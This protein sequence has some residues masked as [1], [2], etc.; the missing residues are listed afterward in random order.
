M[1]R[2]DIRTSRRQTSKQMAGRCPNRF[3]KTI[4][5]KNLLEPR[6]NVP[7][8][9]LMETLA[10]KQDAGVSIRDRERIAILFIASLE[11][12]LEIDAPQIVRILDV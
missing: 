7:I 5:L 12:T 3:R 6:M 4:G 10:L 11:L 8:S 1:E 2:R 9:C